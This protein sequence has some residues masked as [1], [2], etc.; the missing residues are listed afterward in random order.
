MSSNLTASATRI[1][2]DFS[3][4]ETLLQLGLFVLVGLLAWQLSIKC[5]MSEY[6]AQP[7]SSI[8][9]W[10]LPLFLL[11]A[12]AVDELVSPLA[13]GW[14]QRLFSDHPSL[15]SAVALW[16]WPIQVL[17]CLLVIGPGIVS[18]AVFCRAFIHG[19]GF[20]WC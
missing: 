4:L 14:T 5:P 1:V 3:V 11:M 17:V 16:P 8:D 6:G 13:Q 19:H 15:H 9:R 10:F 12:W 18:A 20:L 7:I 2:L